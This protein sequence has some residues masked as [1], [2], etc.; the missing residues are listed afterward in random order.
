MILSPHEVFPGEHLVKTADHYVIHYPGHEPRKAS[1]LYTHTHHGLCIERDTGCF[2]CGA[3]HG[4]GVLTE[5]HHFFCEWSAMEGIDWAR[6]GEVAA[7]F[8]W[9]NPQSGL[10]LASA[11][12]WEAVAADPTL[13]VDSPAN[14]LVLCPDHHRDPAKGI[15]HVQYPVWI[16]Q[17]FAKPGF[18][19]V[20]RA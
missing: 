16:L 19:F 5:T 10:V 12:D 2:I 17:A 7:R 20:T 4:A 9:R 1:T 6:F 18:E 13:F 8:D 11:F 14:M 3:R 15:H